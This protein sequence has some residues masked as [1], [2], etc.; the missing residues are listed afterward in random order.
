MARKSKRIPVMP[1][2]C[3]TCIFRHDGNQVEIRPERLADIQAYLLKGVPHLCHTPQIKGG[4]DRACRGGRDFQLQCWQRMGMIGE[5]TD[6][7]LNQAMS[8]AGVDPQE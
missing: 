2:Q 6:A 1:E 5:A 3:K 4:P 8:E 7:S